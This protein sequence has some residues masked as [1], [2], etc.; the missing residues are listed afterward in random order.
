M[1][2]HLSQRGVVSISGNTLFNDKECFLY[3]MFLDGSFEGCLSAGILLEEQSKMLW[4]MLERSLQ[5]HGEECDIYS[6]FD[7]CMTEW[8]IFE[9]ASHQ[10]IGIPFSKVFEPHLCLLVA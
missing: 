4:V 3:S 10:A 7:D 5:E 8:Q 9:G 1:L 6:M 2:V